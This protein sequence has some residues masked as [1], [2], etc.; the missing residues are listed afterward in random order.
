[1][2][3][4]RSQ[5]DWANIARHKPHAR[6]GPERPGLQLARRSTRTS[7]DGAAWAD[8]SPNGHASSTTS[9]ARR[10]GRG[11]YKAQRAVR[12]GAEAR[13]TFRQFVTRAREALQRHVRPGR[14]A[15]RHQAA[16]ADHALGDL[17]RAEQRARPR[18]AEQVEGARAASRPA[19][20]PTSRC[21]TRPTARSTAQ[22]QPGKS[23]AVVIGGAVG[24]RT[25]IDHVKFYSAPE[26]PRR[27]MDAISMHPYSLRAG[28]GARPTA[29]PGKGY[30]Q[31]FY[32]LG[33]FHRFIT[34]VKGW[35]GAKFPIWVTE[36]GWQVKRRTSGSAVSLKQ[37]G[38]VPAGRPSRGS[39][40]S[41]RCR[42]WL[43]H[44]PRRADDLA[45]WQSGS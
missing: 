26:A 5:I 16:A 41:R 20:R 37:Q 29:Q 39:R 45:G 11:K 1:M 25:G 21:S 31:P 9:G 14:I 27:K 32:R 10:S 7:S 30:L 15:R 13:P 3:V 19:R 4:I 22:D 18:E 35:R 23:K 44:A 38:A 2:N 12:A 17:E 6:R 43:V 33:N 8:A 36:L 28:P 40:S 42:A 34:F 24:G